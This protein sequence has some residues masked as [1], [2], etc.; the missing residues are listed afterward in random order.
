LKKILGLNQAT[1]PSHSAIETQTYFAGQATCWTWL[2]AG[3]TVITTYT[4]AETTTAS[5]VLRA[6]LHL[7]AMRERYAR[8]TTTGSAKFARDLEAGVAHINLPGILENILISLH[9]RL[10]GFSVHR[11]VI[12][13][14][15]LIKNARSLRKQPSLNP[16]FDTDF[17]S[18]GKPARKISAESGKI[19]CAKICETGLFAFSGCDWMP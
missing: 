18:S 3:L 11:H 12:L 7:L 13:A 19:I 14:I 9:R 6:L 10:A 1:I 5:V 2:R 15:T 8:R 4:A 16:F 17:Q